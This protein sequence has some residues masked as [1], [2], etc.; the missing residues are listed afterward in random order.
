LATKDGAVMPGII[1]FPQVVWNAVERFGEAFANK[2]Q[3]QH[4]AKYFTGLMINDVH[5]FLYFR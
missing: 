1:E 4:F 3:H 5:V 2:P